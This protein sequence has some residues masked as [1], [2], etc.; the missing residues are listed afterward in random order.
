MKNQKADYYLTSMNEVI[1]VLFNPLGLGTVKIHL[2]PARKENKSEDCLIIF[3]GRYFLGLNYSLAILV[4][5]FLRRIYF[6]DGN[7]VPQEKIEI[8]MNSSLKEYKEIFPFQ[9]KNNPKQQLQDFLDTVILVSKGEFEGSPLTDFANKLKAP[10]NMSLLINPLSKDSNWNCNQH[11]IHCC[12]EKMQQISSGELNTSNWISIIEKLWNEIYVSQ[13]TFTGVEPL[14]RNDFIELINHSKNFTT[15]LETNGILLEKS[16]CEALYNANLDSIKI[17]LYSSNENLHNKLVGTDG[18]RKTISGIKSALSTG[19]NVTVETPIIS[20]EQDYITTLSFLR[21]IGVRNVTCS[22]ITKHS[23]S[24]SSIIHESTFESIFKQAVRFCLDTDMNLSLDIPGQISL[25]YLHRFNINP[26]TCGACLSTMAISPKGDVI[27][28]KNWFG[29]DA[30][31]GNIL[32][33]NWDTIW[34][35][36]KSIKIRNRAMQVPHNCPFNE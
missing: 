34:N 11:C 18:F 7:E 8:V 16:I 3:N 29:I 1:Y 26:P 10:I 25:E 28:C 35:N 4:T 14:L 21:N 20:D 24:S 22:N 33:D 6:F 13:I 9:F 15:T 2:I 5:I 19:L 12:R 32:T 31:L 17:T 30:T 23:S 27:P 36:K